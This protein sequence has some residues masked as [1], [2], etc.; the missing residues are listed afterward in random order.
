M[1]SPVGVVDFFVVEGTEYIE[2]LDLLISS[3]TS[4][5]PESKPFLQ[6]ARSLRGSAT[7]AKQY[8]IARVG[9]ALEQVGRALRD[10]KLR[11]DPAVNAVIISSIEN[12]K[13]LMRNVRSL[14]PDDEERVQARLAEL[15]RLTPSGPRAP[16]T[17]TASTNS[18]FLVTGM[19]DLADA[20]DA[21]V[22]APDDAEALAIVL[23]QSRAL[24][25]VA[26]VRDL[27]PLTDVVDAIEHLA[28]TTTLGAPVGTRQLSLFSASA[29]VLRRA[30][31][32][33]AAGRRPDVGSPEAK[34]FAGALAM[35]GTPSAVA[36]VVRERVVAISELFY[37]DGG[38]HVVHTAPAP[39]TTPVERFRLSII[40]EGQP[41]LF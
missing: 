18:T 41:S 37:D 20:L 35:V 15:E 27:A 11:W 25:G 6:Y 10:G 26:L 33:L 39:P 5:G 32:E 3:A 13:I 23:E 28:R 22:A 8:S 9:A 29:G 36:P 16:L 12:L 7:M 17:P 1:S 21:L 40:T 30:S 38:Q 2:R 19:A 31:G 24:R 14:T 34:R 4:T